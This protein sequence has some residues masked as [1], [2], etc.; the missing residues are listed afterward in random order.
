MPRNM[1]SIDRWIRVALGMGLLSLT[2]AGPQTAWGYLG[3]LPL[4]TALVGFCPL[5]ALFGW[6][7][8][9]PLA[10]S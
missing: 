1:G 5:Y 6:S 7:T 4:L 9:N 8:N 3:F 2:F 10:K